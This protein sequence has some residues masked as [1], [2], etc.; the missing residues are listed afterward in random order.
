[1]KAFDAE[2]GEGDDAVVG[3]ISMAISASQSSFFTEFPGDACDASHGMDLV[4]VHCQAAI[5]A[6]LR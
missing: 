5:A 3:F 4:D 1:M 2:F 6:G